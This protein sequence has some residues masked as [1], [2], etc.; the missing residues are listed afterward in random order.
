MA[1]KKPLPPAKKPTPKPQRPAPAPEPEEEEEGQDETQDQDEETPEQPTRPVRTPPQAQ[2]S[3]TGG[4][5]RPR[6][7]LFEGDRN[8]EIMCQGTFAVQDLHEVIEAAAG[9]S[10]DPD[11]IRVKIFEVSEQY[12]TGPTRR[13]SLTFSGKQQQRTPQRGGPQRGNGG[14]WAAKNAKRW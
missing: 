2:G 4:L 9:D 14:G 13:Y 12:Q 8:S 6:G 7:S 5:H 11:E 10:V 3:H 1:A